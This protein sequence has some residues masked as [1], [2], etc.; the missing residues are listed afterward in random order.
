MES[1]TKTVGKIY[2]SPEVRREEKRT[3]KRHGTT[4]ESD[5]P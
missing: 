2:P 4:A 3:I 5:F 1:G